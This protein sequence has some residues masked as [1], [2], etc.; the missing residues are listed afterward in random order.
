MFWFIVIIGII[1]ALVSCYALIAAAHHGDEMMESF[2]S[3]QEN[4]KKF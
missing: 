2:Y 4:R 1:V 3:N